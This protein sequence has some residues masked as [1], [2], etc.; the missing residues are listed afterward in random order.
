MGIVRKSAHTTLS[1]IAVQMISTNILNGEIK[2]V[3]GIHAGHVIT[4]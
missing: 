1:S 3:V 4:M 2:S